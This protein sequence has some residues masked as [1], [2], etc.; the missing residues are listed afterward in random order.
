MAKA[1]SNPADNAFEQVKWEK[2]LELRKR[3]V[4]VKELEAATKA[5]EAVIKEEETRIKDREQRLKNREL[6]LK[7]IELRKSRFT[8]PVFLAIIGAT[9]TA[10]GTAIG[11]W[12]TTRSQQDLERLK[13]DSML[14][15]E[16]IRTGDN[17]QK[18]KNN[19]EFLVDANLI[20][21]EPR[22]DKIRN[23]LASA[24]PIPTLPATTQPAP[25][26]PGLAVTCVTPQETDLEAIASEIAANL[27]GTPTVTNV[28]MTTAKDSATL[29][30]DL[31]FGSARLGCPGGSRAGKV[32]ITMRKAG[33]VVSINV[34]APV[35]RVLWAAFAPNMANDFVAGLTKLM[36]KKVGAGKVT[37]TQ[38]AT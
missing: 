3:E 6:R 8:N 37:C 14:F 36:E 29:D 31:A 15:L 32:T 28:Q 20:N 16:V 27:K 33:N 10:A 19:L 26:G 35:P 34:D 18:A 5:R 25:I 2:E 4:S 17:I 30:V 1:P 24:K 38:A 13:A 22:R 9:V 7:I 23:Y 12:W 21:D 11:S